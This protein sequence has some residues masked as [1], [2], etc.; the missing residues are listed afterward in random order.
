M[1]QVKSANQKEKNHPQRGREMTQSHHNNSL[2]DALNKIVLY[3]CEGEISHDKAEIL[4]ADSDSQYYVS[5]KG[6]SNKRCVFRFDTQ[7]PVKIGLNDNKGIK[8]NKRNDLTVIYESLGKII[9]LV[10][11]FKGSS[12]AIDKKSTE[13]D[14]SID[15]I[16]QIVLSAEFVKYAISLLDA[17]L[18]IDGKEYHKQDIE[19][20]GIIVFNNKIISKIRSKAPT[21]KIFHDERTFKIN[22]KRH[23]HLKNIMRYIHRICLNNV[24]DNKAEI[25]RAHV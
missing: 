5:L 19:F 16:D 1:L 9:V 20:H 21:G 15:G 14:C 6:M 23:P 17:R 2:I 22:F 7:P 24:T 3:N 12:P 11:D 4:H 25:G 10:I 8:V 18:S 13:V